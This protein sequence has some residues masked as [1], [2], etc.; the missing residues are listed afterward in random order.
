[1][2]NILLS[3]ISYDIWFY[4]SHI[5]LHTKLLY[6]IHKK[7]HIKIIPTFLDT[8]IGHVLEGPLQSIGTFIPFIFLDYNIYDI[9]IILLFLNIRGMMRHDERFIFLIGNHHLLHHKYPNYNYGEYWIDS[10][11][12]TKYI[13]NNEYKKGYIYM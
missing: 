10:L 2:L 5:L 1:M 13:N 3:I 6:K 11:C 8:Y 7:H 4:I 12:G 9:I